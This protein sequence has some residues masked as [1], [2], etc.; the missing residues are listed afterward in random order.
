LWCIDTLASRYGWTKSYCENELYWEEFFDLVQ[1]SANFSADER[2]AELKFH[3]MIHADKKSASKWKDMPI[4]F[5]AEQE[6]NENVDV[7]GV[8]QLPLNLKDLVYTER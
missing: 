8:S 2:N 3:F 5:P 7:S 4:P 1:I 6:D